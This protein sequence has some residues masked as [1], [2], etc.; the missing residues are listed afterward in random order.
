MITA[1]VTTLSAAIIARAYAEITAIDAVGGQRS[2][3]DS[4]DDPTDS[5][6]TTDAEKTP[7]TDAEPA[8]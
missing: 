1:F 3:L 7:E 4:G 5:E 8:A 6:T 2:E